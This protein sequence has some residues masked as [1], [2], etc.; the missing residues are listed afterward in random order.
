MD[1]LPPLRALQ[2]FDTLGRCG[3]IAEAA[4]PVGGSAGAVSSR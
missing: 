4:K 3:S 2:A 1:N